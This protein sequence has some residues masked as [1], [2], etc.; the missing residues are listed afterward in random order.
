MLADTYPGETF[1]DQQEL[2]LFLVTFVWRFL[3]GQYH[4]TDC[5]QNENIGNHQSGMIK[6]YK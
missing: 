6:H 4:R 2:A 5:L 1:E 3:V